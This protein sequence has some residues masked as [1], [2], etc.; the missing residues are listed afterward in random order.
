MPLYLMKAVVLRGMLFV[1]CRIPLE[2][3]WGASGDGV[4]FG[5]RD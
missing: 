1:T 3:F 4:G 2:G 5:G